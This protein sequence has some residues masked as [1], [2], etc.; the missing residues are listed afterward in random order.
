M[1]KVQVENPYASSSSS[2]TEQLSTER[3][4]SPIT[5]AFRLALP[6]LLFPLSFLIA[7]VLLS[8]LGPEQPPPFDYL[9][10]LVIDVPLPFLG[11]C[12]IYLLLRT[13]VFY[14]A[15]SKWPLFSAI[16]GVAAFFLMSP[17]YFAVIAPLFQDIDNELLHLLLMLL[18][19]S[20]SALIIEVALAF[21]VKRIM[22]KNLHRTTDLA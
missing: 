18:A 6:C 20:C 1:N 12:L 19:G 2:S 14:R 3:S 21:S 7:A 17:I 15:L 10:T 8:Q 4:T 5:H 22:R 11:V 9:K 16:G 13:V